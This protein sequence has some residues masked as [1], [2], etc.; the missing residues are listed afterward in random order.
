LPFLVQ[1]LKI[2][3]RSGYPAMALRRIPAENSVPVLLELLR[4]DASADGREQ[5][6]R[7]LGVLGSEKKLGQAKEEAIAGLRGAM[8]DENARVRKYAGESLKWIE[9]R[10]Q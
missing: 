6:A 4:N 5:A 9:G 10:K 7:I 1:G 8:Q 3:R 2:E